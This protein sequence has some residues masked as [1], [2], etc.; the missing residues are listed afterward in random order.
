MGC[1]TLTTIRPALSDEE[2][3]AEEFATWRAEV[4]IGKLIAARAQGN[5][6]PIPLRTSR[7][8]VMDHMEGTMPKSQIVSFPLAELADYRENRLKLD[9]EVEL[10]R[11]TRNEIE[12]ICA[13]RAKNRDLLDSFDLSDLDRPNRTER[14]FILRRR[15]RRLEGVIEARR[16]AMKVIAAQH[17]RA[18][19]AFYDADTEA[20]KLALDRLFLEIVREAGRL[21]DRRQEVGRLFGTAPPSNDRLLHLREGLYRIGR[22]FASTTEICSPR[23]SSKRGRP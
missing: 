10:A 5:E 19:Q 15:E 17:R 3:E 6:T 16:H 7:T 13:E 21:D 8:M 9:A 11:A 23:R 14:L 22:S 20:E 1:G 2:Y 12:L 4:A 18:A